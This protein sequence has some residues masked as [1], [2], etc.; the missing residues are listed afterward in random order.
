MPFSKS[1][2]DRLTVIGQRMGGLDSATSPNLPRAWNILYI[3]ENRKFHHLSEHW[4]QPQLRFSLIFPNRAQPE[5][6]A[7]V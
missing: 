6:S 4:Q 1:N 7:E 5:T 3:Y 2:A